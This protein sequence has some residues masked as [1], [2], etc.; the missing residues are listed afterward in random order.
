MKERNVSGE[1]SFLLRMLPEYAP[2]SALID[3]TA[4]GTVGSDEVYDAELSQVLGQFKFS[5]IL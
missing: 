2:N 1:R 5:V 4:I 3:V